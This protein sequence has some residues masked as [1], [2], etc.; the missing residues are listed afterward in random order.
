MSLKLGRSRERSGVVFHHEQTSYE[1]RGRCPC[2]MCLFPWPAAQCSCTCACCPPY[3]GTHFRRL[4]FFLLWEFP[5]LVQLIL[6][7]GQNEHFGRYLSMKSVYEQK[8][9]YSSLLIFGLI[10][11]AKLLKLL[12]I[13][14]SVGVYSLSNLL[15][16]LSNICLFLC[17][18]VFRQ[19]CLIFFV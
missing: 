3:A 17:L 18:Y 9:T 6:V 5:I 4:Y 13:P 14:G 19:V 2:C 1:L 10:T 15:N 11:S 16:I 8:Y 12:A 7:T